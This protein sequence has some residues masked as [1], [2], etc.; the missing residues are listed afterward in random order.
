MVRESLAAKKQRMAL[1]LEALYAAYPK[2]ACSLDHRSPFQLLIATMLS[3]Q[4]TDE[5]VN[6]V[7]PELF[8][9]YPTARDMARAPVEHL[10]ELVRSTGFFNS[11]ARN[12]SACARQ[13]MEEHDGAVPADLA[14][15]V[16]LPGVPVNGRAMTLPI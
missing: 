9:Y 16:K 4:C 1:I 12:M 13:L 8:K 3:A 14:S 7:T 10:A 5:R 15:L 6:K 11:K 2:A